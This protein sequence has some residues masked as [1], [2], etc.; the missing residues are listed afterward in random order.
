[1]FSI[2]LTIVSFPM[3]PFSQPYLI[4]PYHISSLFHILLYDLTRLYNVFR[5]YSL[6]IKIVRV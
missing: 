1:M 4:R 2:V 3:G 6:V 5:H